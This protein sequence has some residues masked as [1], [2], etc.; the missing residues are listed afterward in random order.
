M[1]PT[2]KANQRK[3]MRAVDS[4]IDAIRQ[5]GVQCKALVSAKA[6]FA[7]SHVSSLSFQDRALLLP[8][9]AE[10]LPKD[11]Y[12][13]FNPTSAGYRKSVHRVP[14]FTKVRSFALDCVERVELIVGWLVVVDTAR[15]PY[16]I[17]SVSDYDW[18]SGHP[19]VRTNDLGPAHLSCTITWDDYHTV[20]YLAEPGGSRACTASLT[21]PDATE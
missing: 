16:R 20:T 6:W 21:A 14:K 5:S 12:T 10:M 13:T 17:L 18:L 3:R 11:K 7:E 9:E 2:R 1:S 19:A 8:T 4:V 15:E